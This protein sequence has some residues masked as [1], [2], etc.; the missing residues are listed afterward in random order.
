MNILC[1]IAAT[2]SPHHNPPPQL[3]EGAMQKTM[4][5]CHFKLFVIFFLFAMT[6][7][8]SG[9]KKPDVYKIDAE[10]NAYFHNNRGLN[11]IDEKNYNA[12]IQ[13]YKIAISLNPNT[14]A[15]AVYYNNLGE[16]YMMACFYKY[17]QDCFERS[18]TQ[19]PL[20]FT[21]YQN[22]AKCYK[23]QGL[24]NSKINYYNHAAPPLNMVML[25]LLYIENG[26]IQGGIIKLDEF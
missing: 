19:Y 1:K 14:Q 9:Y 18:I 3:W 8:S 6:F 10:K 15:T 12:A 25:G 22:L 7:V 11:Y 20:N 4:L 26:N 17:A 2:L 5:N 13:E 16:V 23:A 24:I 21:Y